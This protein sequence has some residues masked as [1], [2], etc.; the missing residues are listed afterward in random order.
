M[1]GVKVN[2]DEPLGLHTQV[3]GEIRGAIADG[4]AKQGDRLR[5]I[6]SIEKALF[7]AVA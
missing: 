5:E 7:E 2:R 1:L 4:E 3:A 6:G